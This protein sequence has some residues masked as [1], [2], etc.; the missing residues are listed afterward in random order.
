M[1]LIAT[2]SGRMVN[3]TFLMAGISFQGKKSI[4][5]FMMEIVRSYLEIRY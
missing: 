3:N 1:K 2:H 4:N 5:N